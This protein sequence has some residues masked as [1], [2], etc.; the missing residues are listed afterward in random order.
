VHGPISSTWGLTLYPTYSATYYLFL[1]TCSLLTH[2][3]SLR[4]T[5][6]HG[7]QRLTGFYGR[8]GKA[9][10]IETHPGGSGP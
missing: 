5:D 7:V 4:Y 6:K 3:R 9:G 2:N 10:R 1:V 8:P